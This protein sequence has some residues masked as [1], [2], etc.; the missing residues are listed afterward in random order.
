MKKKSLTYALATA[1]LLGF[2]SCDL[3][4][5]DSELCTFYKIAADL[6]MNDRILYNG[7]QKQNL[8]VHNLR[9]G[10]IF[11]GGENPVYAFQI[12]DWLE[13]GVVVAND[14][15]ADACSEGA[16]A[17]ATLT[18]PTAIHR[19]Q[20]G[21][22]SQYP[23][24]LAFTPAIANGSFQISTAQMQFLYPGNYYFDFEANQNR[25]IDEHSF[26]NNLFTSLQGSYGFT[27]SGSDDEYRVAIRV[28]GEMPTADSNERGAPIRQAPGADSPE[29]YAQSK[30]VQYFN[31]HLRDN[32]QVV[33]R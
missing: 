24:S 22:A 15:L 10:E 29:L 20:F 1:L 4:E 13:I 21:N 32:I 3:I 5:E 9:T 17:P 7:Q 11:F 2:S 33:R 27:G 14:Y 23:L 25:Q 28:V 30:L 12:G 16:D 31:E 26:T 8:L 18:M 19:D 6:F